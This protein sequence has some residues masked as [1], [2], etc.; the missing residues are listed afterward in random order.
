MVQ[1]GNRGRSRKR[2]KSTIPPKMGIKRLGES[3]EG[4]KRGIW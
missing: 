4:T 3:K 2:D 1:D